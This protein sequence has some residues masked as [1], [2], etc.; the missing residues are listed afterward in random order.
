M[1]NIIFT[2]FLCLLIQ[3]CVSTST[4]FKL[5]PQTLNGQQ[6]IYEEGVEGVI[7]QKKARVAIRPSADTYSSENRPTILVSLYGTEKPFDF[8]TEDIKVFVDGNPHRVFTYDELIAEI[9]SRHEKLIED[10]KLRYDEKTR[11]VAR[12]ARKSTAIQGPHPGSSDNKIIGDTSQ[13]GYIYDLEE[14][15]YGQSDIEGRTEKEIEAIEIETQQTLY[16]LYSTMLRKTTVSPNEWFSGYVTMEKIP[17]PS[18]V[19]E[20]K[21]IVTVAGEEHEFLLNHFKVQ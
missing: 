17:N 16:A 21:V 10:Q 8:S 1:K 12:E 11:E 4:L 5:V 2:L 19:H 3:G 7:S 9:K 15:A 6:K 18:R 20:I 14:V 13:Y